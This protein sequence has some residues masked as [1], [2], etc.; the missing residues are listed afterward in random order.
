MKIEAPNK[1]YSGVSAG[2]TFVNGVGETDQPHLI[3]WFLEHG[4]SVEKEIITILP[5]ELEKMKKDELKQLA[6]KLGAVYETS[7]TNE[8]LIS[9]IRVAYEEWKKAGE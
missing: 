8:Q 3:E 6:E 9:L 5:G 7:S 2:V 1:Q 4:Y